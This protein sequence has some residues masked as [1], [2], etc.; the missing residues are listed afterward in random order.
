MRFTPIS[1]KWIQYYSFAIMIFSCIC[2][3]M[4][5]GYY[6][7]KQGILNGV[8]NALILLIVLFLIYFF[9]IEKITLWEMFRLKHILCLLGGAVG[10]M[11]G[12]NSN[13]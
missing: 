9:A 4:V 5:A 11:I 10:G 13:S 7:K 6:Q 8:M 12:V 1:E 2:S 3:G